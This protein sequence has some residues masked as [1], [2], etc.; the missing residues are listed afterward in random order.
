MHN[1]IGDVA[2]TNISREINYFHGTC[3]VS[4]IKV[5]RFTLVSGVFLAG[6]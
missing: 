5:L 6:S 1:I 4:K 2:L 3:A